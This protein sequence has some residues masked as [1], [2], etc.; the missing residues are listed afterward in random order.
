MRASNTCSNTQHEG[1]KHLQ[2]HTTRGPQTPAATHITRASNTCSN[3]Q[4][5][6]LK[7]LQQ[8]T[9]RGPQ[10]PAATHNTR[11]SN[12]CSN[13]QHEGLKHLQAIHTSLCIVL[14][15]YYTAGQCQLEKHVNNAPQQTPVPCG[16]YRL[17]MMTLLCTY[18]PRQYSLLPTGCSD[19]ETTHHVNLW[20]QYT[21]SL[22]LLTLSKT[23]DTPLLCL[24]C[25]SFSTCS[26]SRPSRSRTSPTSRSR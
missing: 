21:P 26:S 2:Q 11:A 1:H 16:A 4:H 8:H 6:G 14:I 23:T 19:P 7:H 3:T 20:T 17:P 22:C 13:T 24:T 10:T 12:T 25:S 9:T 5:E 18:P 15:Y